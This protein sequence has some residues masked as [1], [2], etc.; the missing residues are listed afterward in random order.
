MSKSMDK[1]N[2]KIGKISETNIHNISEIKQLNYK[3]NKEKNRNEKL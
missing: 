1:L 2:F 3:L